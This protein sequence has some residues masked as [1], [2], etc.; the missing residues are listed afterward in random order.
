MFLVFYL[1]FFPTTTNDAD[2][3]VSVSGTPCESSTRQN[4]GKRSKNL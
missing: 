3:P 1:V 2:N 4:S